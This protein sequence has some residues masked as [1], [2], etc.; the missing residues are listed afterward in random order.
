MITIII[1]NAL[2]IHFWAE[3]C[4]NTTYTAVP[5]S[6]MC[7]IQNFTKLKY[8]KGKVCTKEGWE[9]LRGTSKDRENMKKQGV[10][11]AIA[12]KWATAICSSHLINNWVYN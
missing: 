9:K 4:V 12:R 11:K 2:N 8:I 3:K 7:T 1:I 5:I 6:N 10:E